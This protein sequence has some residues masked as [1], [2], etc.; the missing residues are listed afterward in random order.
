MDLP[1]RPPAVLQGAL[2][3][4]VASAAFSCLSGIIR[5]LGDSG[6][7]P[8][9]IVAF[10]SLFGLLVLAPWLWRVGPGGLKTRQPALIGLRGLLGLTAMATWFWAITIMPLGEAAGLSFTAP[11]FAT[12]IAVVILREQVGLRRWSALLIGFT[13]AMIILRPGAA[14]LTPGAILVLGSAVA[15]AGAIVIIRL[16]TR[17]DGVATIVAWNQ[18]IVL[19]L[20]VLP[21]LYFWTTPTWEQVAWMA[22]LGGFATAAHMAITKAFSLA[23][24][25]AV[26]PFDFCRLLFSAAI[27][28]AFFGERLD[29]WVWIGAGVI[30][31]SASYTAHRETRLARQAVA[32]AAAGPGDTV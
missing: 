25:S 30:F 29:I 12:V 21:A 18:M 2:L 4:V 27:G 17:T 15:M 10:R 32:R 23:E 19:P 8:F 3:M 7:H 20:S 14:T 13:G 31:S 1:W 16:L 9:E 6:I 11:L 26:M 22:L 28:F 24:T 5:H